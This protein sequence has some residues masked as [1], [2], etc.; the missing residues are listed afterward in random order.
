MPPVTDHA[1]LLKLLM[2][3]LVSQR[4]LVLCQW[5]PQV[6]CRHVVMRPISPDLF[7]ARQ[8]VRIFVEANVEHFSVVLGRK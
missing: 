1:S 4:I 6:G 8:A 7:L 3:R 5:N 2:G